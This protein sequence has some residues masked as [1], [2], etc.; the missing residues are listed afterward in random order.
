LSQPPTSKIKKVKTKEVR[1]VISKLKPNKAP[2]PDN[3]QNIVLKQ[4]PDE[5][6]KVLSHI[7]NRSIQLNHYPPSWKVAK[8]INL[9]KPNKDHKLAANYRPISLLNS[10]GKIAEKIILCR[11]QKFACVNNIVSNEQFGFRG[12]HSTVHQLVRVTEYITEQFNK[13]RSTGA[14][15]LDIEKAFDRVWHTGLIY[16]LIQYKFPD[17]LIHLINSYINSRKFFVQ[18]EDEKSSLRPIQAG[19]P[20]GSLLGPF[21]FT[22]FIND[23]PKH[24]NTNIALYADDTV[25]YTSSTQPKQ[26]TTYLQ[27][28]MIR[29]QDWFTKWKIKINP[30]KCESVI[31]SKRRHN[32]VGAVQFNNSPIPWKHEVKYLGV[33]LDKRLN[34]S[35][36]INLQIGK[37]SGRLAYL[38]CLLLSEQLN[39]ETKVTLYKMLIRPIL[40][41]AIQAWAFAPDTYF[42]KV[43]RFQN[44]VLKLI[45]NAP[46]YTRM[47]DLHTRLNIETI[48]TYISA[49]TERFY[50]NLPATGNDL[51]A[52]LGRYSTHIH[53]KHK[54]PLHI[55]YHNPR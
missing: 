9:P 7:I 36:H 33:T 25:T 15:F 8:V 31:F 13:N 29:L 24:D 45:T 28:H 2:G 22:I 48:N 34:F 49:N 30:A 6:L 54:R 43:Q 32:P 27:R 12:R 23:I 19:V 55:L 37:A 53:Y 26:L 46:R 50:T 51:I 42:K 16:K 18:V 39:T 44:R 1:S 47:S 11:L 52:G 5:A 4:L 10:L 35:R 41:Y 38:K 17:K 20:Q 3:I 21:L 40:T 14:V